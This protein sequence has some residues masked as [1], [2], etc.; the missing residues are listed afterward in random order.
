MPI[1]KV[2]VV[3]KFGIIS[4]KQRL[5]ITE[6]LCRKAL[7]D[8]TV[9]HHSFITHKNPVEVTEEFV[10]RYN[11][12]SSETE[13]K[14]YETLAL[15]ML[16]RI[17]RRVGLNSFG[18]GRHVNLPFAWA[19]LAQLIECK[20]I[21]QD[22]CLNCLLLSFGQAPI[23]QNHVAALFY[24]TETLVLLLRS[25]SLQEP[26]LRSTEIKM[27]KVCQLLFT[28]LYFHKMAN[29]LQGCNDF[30]NRLASY[31]QGL[32][33]CQS[34]YSF[35][36]DA[37]LA[38]KFMIQV[39][40]IILASTDL[41]VDEIKG[42]LPASVNNEKKDLSANL[43]PCMSSGESCSGEVRCPSGHSSWMSSSIH[44]LSPALWHALDVWKSQNLVAISKIPDKTRWQN[45]FS[46]SLGSLIQ[47][48]YSPDNEACWIDCIV[49]V[50]I[51]AEAAKMNLTTL[52]VFQNLACHCINQNYLT[53]E[54]QARP[55][56]HATEHEF[57][58]DWKGTVLG[59]NKQNMK[60]LK[61]QLNVSKPVT[62]TEVQG[63]ENVN[64]QKARKAFPK[65]NT[66]SVPTGKTMTKTETSMPSPTQMSPFSNFSSDIMAFNPCITVESSF[67]RWHWEVAFTYTSLLGDIVLY[68]NNSLIQKRA[69]L[70]TNRDITSKSF[71][72]E[73]HKCHEKFLSQEAIN[74]DSSLGCYVGLF[75]LTF[76]H[77]SSNQPLQT[78]NNW[79]WKIRFGAIQTLIRIC[80]SLSKDTTK[81]GLQTAAWGILYQANTTEH[82][83]RVL[84]ALRVGY[85]QSNLE[86]FAKTFHFPGSLASHMANGL[87]KIYLCVPF[88][89]E[90]PREKILIQ[91]GVANKDTVG[92]MQRRKKE[93]C[94]KKHR[95]SLREEILFRSTW[96][97][98]PMNY[99]TRTTFCLRR[100]I[101]D[102]WRKD[103]IQESVK[104]ECPKIKGS[105]V[106]CPDKPESLS[107]EHCLQQTLKCQNKIEAKI[108][109]SEED[110]R[111]LL[112]EKE[113]KEI[114]PEK[115]ESK[116]K[117]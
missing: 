91:G 21:I 106:D 28:R 34:L 39:T 74:D 60:P 41:N 70:G 25:E 93:K 50:T 105:L 98:T 117:C 55:P 97:V 42:H 110:V 72:A 48:S 52:K 54:S 115:V 2:P 61:S 19:E 40:S 31:M 116:E 71:L 87:V 95:T 112:E 94:F 13:R 100:L 9:I 109:Q 107:I 45:S 14:K 32:S 85:V 113:T 4:E 86:M 27:L 63:G 83:P 59:T 23:H 24:L 58:D 68:A 1:T 96:H 114:S 26:F 81:E 99:N 33:K 12:A 76:F 43:M 53:S 67:Y 62:I 101:E 88:Y 37:Q 29:H 89:K 46:E 7:I 11:E 35:Y 77:S 111:K 44:D 69:L 47:C 90:Q 66:L 65:G 17:K 8:S 51:L 16:A 108:F 84:E 64:E 36:P 79:S 22:E 103:M 10:Q 57:Q 5:E 3:N 49:A 92:E 20:G 80:E 73:R 18:I 38:L 6:R 75:D 82:D 104:E 78:E 15:K 30:K 102:Q 56:K